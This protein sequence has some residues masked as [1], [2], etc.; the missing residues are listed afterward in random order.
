[1][2]KF[3]EMKLLLNLKLK[4]WGIPKTEKVFTISGNTNY[5]TDFTIEKGKSYTYSMIA[6]DK[7]GNESKRS[8][9]IIIKTNER[10]D[11]KQNEDKA[12]NVS[13][14][15]G[16]LNWSGSFGGISATGFNIFSWVNGVAGWTFNGVTSVV[17]S[18]SSSVVGLM[19]GLSHIFVVIPVDNNGNAL[20][21]GLPISVISIDKKS[22]K[23][24]DLTLYQGQ[25]WKR[26][27]SF[28]SATDENGKAVPWSDGRIDTN[29]A[30]VDTNKPGVY[31][32]KYTFKGKA[33]N[34]DSKCK[35]TVKENKSTIVIKYVQYSW[36]EFPNGFEL[37]KSIS[38]TGEIG[39]TYKTTAAFIPGYR[40]EKT[41]D[42]TNGVFSD[43]PQTVTY[44]YAN[45]GYD[46]L[47]FAKL[48]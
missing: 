43:E 24:K 4:T 5:Y 1:M 47:D 40:V 14:S 45:L 6:V 11:G 10:N 22:I 7:A 35:V 9:R 23:T 37:S 33:G 20:A 21:V 36:W 16:T 32:L 25:S 42:N 29:G 13:F 19:P 15:S 26:E 2:L 44:A 3:I 12:E 34:I 30:T 27:D 48:G 39:E 28:V 46:I 18:L 31:E 38:I 8:N 41:S 17:G